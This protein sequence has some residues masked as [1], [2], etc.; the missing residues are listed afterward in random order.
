MAVMC[1]PERERESERSGTPTLH[2]QADVS[3]SLLMLSNLLTVRRGAHVHAPFHVFG[4]ALANVLEFDLGC[5]KSTFCLE[6]VSTLSFARMT[7]QRETGGG[8]LKE[9]ATDFL[10]RSSSVEILTPTNGQLLARRPN[11]STSHLPEPVTK[12]ETKTEPTPP[13]RQTSA[14]TGT[15][16]LSS[17]NNTPMQN[18]TVSPRNQRSL[19]NVRLGEKVPR[20]LKRKGAQLPPLRMPQTNAA[21][22]T[23]PNATPQGTPIIGERG[24]IFTI[25]SAVPDDP[26]AKNLPRRESGPDPNPLVKRRPS[27]KTP[28]TSPKE[29]DEEPVW[30]RRLSQLFVPPREDEFDHEKE[31][32]ETTSLLPKE[33]PQLK[34]RRPPTPSPEIHPGDHAHKP[35]SSTA[36]IPSEKKGKSE[37]YDRKVPEGKI[38]FKDEGK[39][40]KKKVEEDDDDRLSVLDKLESG[41]H[42][43]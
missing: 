12:S 5:A 22:P 14:S 26:I 41:R 10:K 20:S 30:Q 11:I 38:N 42:D 2:R 6:E 35:P 23:P 18:G 33:S 1:R 32:Q 19:E 40:R 15:L 4:I 28:V 37:R 8:Y 13:D 29:D 43:R 16:A 7:E 34:P 24:H 27:T 36:P 25:S 39:K 21:A 3:R 9:S 17:K 31:L